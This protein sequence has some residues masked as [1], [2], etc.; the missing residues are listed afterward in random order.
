[1]LSNKDTATEVEKMM[2]QC[3]ETLDESV[4]RVME[5]CPDDE[6]KAY[7]RVIAQIMGSIYLDVMQPIYRQYPD[8]EPEELRRPR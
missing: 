2:R 7:R 3:S 6:F 5:T 8:L 4:R 1:M